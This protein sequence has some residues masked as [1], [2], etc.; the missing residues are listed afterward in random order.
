VSNLVL[1]VLILTLSAFGHLLL[2]IFAGFAPDVQRQI[3]LHETA[4]K[5]G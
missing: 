4:S 2:T 1:I 5:S 3:S